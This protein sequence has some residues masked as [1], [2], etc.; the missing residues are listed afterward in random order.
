M[1]AMRERPQYSKRS[2]HAV[3]RDGWQAGHD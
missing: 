1:K 2:A 3:A